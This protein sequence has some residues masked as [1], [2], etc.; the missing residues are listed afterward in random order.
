MVVH[1]PDHPLAA[2]SDNCRLELKQLGE[3]YAICERELSDAVATLGLRIAAGEDFHETI[4]EVK[5][6]RVLAQQ[7]SDELLAAIE[8][9]RTQ[10]CAA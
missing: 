10:A 6:L 7:A 4:L 9:A 5:R 1:Q 3:T 8:P 2:H